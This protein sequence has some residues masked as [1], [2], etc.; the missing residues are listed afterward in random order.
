MEKNTKVAAAVSGPKGLTS[1]KAEA[2]L[3]NGRQRDQRTP[4]ERIG[5]AAK[6]AENTLHVRNWKFKNADRHFPHEPLLRR[7][8]KYFGQAKGGPL[9]VD[10][11]VSDLDVN[12]CKRKAVVMASEG[13]RYCYLT[14]DMNLSD[15]LKQLEKKKAS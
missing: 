5:L 14:K 9:Y 2:R 10:E 7:V 1:D 4:E 11:P 6:V 8:D 12:H 3:L 13:L 15:A